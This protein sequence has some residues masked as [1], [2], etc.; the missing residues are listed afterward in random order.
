MRTSLK[1][2]LKVGIVMY[3]FPNTFSLY[4]L[5]RMV[6]RAHII[7]MSFVEPKSYHHW[8]MVAI[9]VEAEAIAQEGAAG[10]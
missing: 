5:M 8:E 7:V 2:Y 4:L 10:L 1:Q 9:A 3:P 6:E